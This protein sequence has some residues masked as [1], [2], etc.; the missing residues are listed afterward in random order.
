MITEDILDLNRNIKEEDI[1]DA[2][3]LCFLG[4]SEWMNG[5][6]LPQSWK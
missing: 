2:E 1:M 4:K 6:S 5:H 3:A